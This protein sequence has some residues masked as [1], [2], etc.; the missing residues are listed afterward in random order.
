LLITFITI[1]ILEIYFNPQV[2]FYSPLIG[3]FPGNIY[4]EGL[5]PDLKLF[6]HQVLITIYFLIVPFLFFRKKVFLNQRKKSLLVLI[7]IIPIVFHFLSP[8][9]GYST[10]FSKLE[11]T[12]NKKVLTDNCTLYYSDVDSSEAAFI[13]L[14]T[15]Y[16]FEKL[17]EVLKVIPSEKTKVYLFNSRDQKK[18]LFGAGNADVAKPWQYSVF[19]SKDS[20]F[21]TLKHELS[22]IFSAEFGWGIFKL[23]H[24]F[25]AASIEGLAQSIEGTYDELN[26]LDLTALAYHENYKTNITDLFNGFNFFKSNSLLSYNYSGAFYDFL[27]R[28]YGIN[29]VKHFYSTGNLE[30]SF[31][32]K[33]DKIISSFENELKS[34]NPIGSKNMADYYFG[35]LSIIQKICPRYVSDRL[36][37]AFELLNKKEFTA[38]EKLF[39]E[40]DKKVINYPAIIGLAEIYSK[41]QHISKSIEL[42]ESKLDKFSNTPYYFNLLFVLGDL[43]AKNGNFNSAINIFEKLVESNPNLGIKR[44]SLFRLKLLEQNIILDYLSDNDTLKFNVLKQLNENEYDYNTFPILISL[45]KSLKIDKKDFIKIFNKTFVVDDLFKSYGIFKLS[46][47]ILEIGDYSNSRK[48]AAL[49]L[50]YK[51]SNPYLKALEE[52]FDKANWFFYNADKIKSTFIYN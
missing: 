25:N 28:K 43:Y 30:N 19:I 2:Y 24:N 14:H 12:L 23:A 15:E 31:Q 51:K 46:Q 36:S 22:H 35:R 38:A 9:L 3:F 29:K 8:Y 20:W 6:S 52:N 50:R 45:S 13:A 49:S 17:K 32:E 18:E 47:Y 1:P 41:Q 27:T 5:S 10:T 4:D 48:L 34:I 11:S 16:Y 33:S 44:A 40:I 42:I 26:I 39:K 21:G 37:K 7:L